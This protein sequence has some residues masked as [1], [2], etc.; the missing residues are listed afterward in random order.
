MAVNPLESLDTSSALETIDIN[1]ICERRAVD[2]STLIA[3]VQR[4]VER[5]MPIILPIIL[6]YIPRN[7]RLTI[8]D[9]EAIKSILKTGVGATLDSAPSVALTYVKAI[10]LCSAELL[11]RRAQP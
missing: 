3:C 2:A 1:A 9:L 7:V 10:E 5:S 11:S 6:K 4:D 8:E